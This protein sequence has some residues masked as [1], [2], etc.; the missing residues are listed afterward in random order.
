M[1]LGTSIVVNN[2]L[3]L[4]PHTFTQDYRVKWNSITFHNLQHF[5]CLP[6]LLQED[7][8]NILVRSK[9]VLYLI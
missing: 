9:P 8:Q 5:Q 3:I 2:F 6:V 1:I 4:T 7:A